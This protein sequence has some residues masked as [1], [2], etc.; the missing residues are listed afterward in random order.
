MLGLW[1]DTQIAGHRA[2]VEACHRHGA[3]VLV[4]LSHAGM[5]THEAAGPM[6]G[7]SQVPWRGKQSEALTLTEI[8]QIRNH[9]LKPQFVRK[10]PVMTVFSCMRATATSSTS[11]SVPA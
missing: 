4:Q 7:P 11:L 10:K 6:K 3:V 5:Q 2:I 1:E 8:H 9:S